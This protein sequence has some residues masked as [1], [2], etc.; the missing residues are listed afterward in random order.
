MTINTKQVTGRRELRFNCYGCIREDVK[1]LTEAGHQKL[2]NWT[3]DQACWHLAAGMDR[4]I[5][6]FDFKVPV[7]IRVIASLM[8]KRILVKT[9][10][11][12]IKLTGKA[13]EAIEP[14]DIADREGV[15]LLLRAIDRFKVEKPCQLS[16]VLG[17]LDPQQW[18]QFH[19]RHAELHLSFFTPAPTHG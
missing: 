3:L 15:E 4:S 5:D 1:K 10:G 19:C 13:A 16:P 6:G 2:G 11:P 14:P 17:K 9:L 7:P 12:G 18:E 8:K